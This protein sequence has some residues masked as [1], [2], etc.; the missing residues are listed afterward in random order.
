MRL[1][2]GLAPFVE[3]NDDAIPNADE[4]KVTVTYETR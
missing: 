1:R 4:Y 2:F 3:F